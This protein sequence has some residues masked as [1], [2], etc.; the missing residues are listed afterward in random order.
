MRTQPRTHVKDFRNATV[1]TALLLF[2]A[3]ALA[4]APH[5]ASTPLPSPLKPEGQEHTPA[6]AHTGPRIEVRPDSLVL[7]TPGDSA[8]FWVYV[9]GRTAEDVSLDIEGSYDRFFQFSTVPGEPGVHLVQT[10]ADRSEYGTYTLIVKASGQERRVPIRIGTPEDMAPDKAV[11]HV[12]LRLL[13]IDLPKTVHEGQRIVLSADL[14]PGTRWY[15]W[16]I[17]GEPVLEG[18]GEDHLDYVA[19]DL[20]AVFFSVV[21]REAGRQ[22]ARWE[23]RTDVI[24][25]PPLTLEATAQTAYRFKAPEGYGA[26]AWSVDGQQLGTDPSFEHQ[27]SAPGVY[28]VECRASEPAQAEAPPFYRRTWTV[29]V[30]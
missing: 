17:N 20:G 10:M 9:D 25:Y 12:P 18:A 27:F 5:S 24:A 23:G 22:V 21:V 28:S 8:Y 7:A 30:R 3:G 13:R 16:R 29:T 1:A 4:Q 14:G 11:T 19:K 6:P 15:H 26:C 2:S